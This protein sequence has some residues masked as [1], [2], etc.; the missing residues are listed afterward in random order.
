MLRAY[1]LPAGP[2]SFPAGT[3]P[4]PRPG[5]DRGG[6]P[7]PLRHRPLHAVAAAAVDAALDRR[8]CGLRLSGGDGQL[9]SGLN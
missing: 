8:R 6:A 5:L 1:H 2:D 4:L 3:R 9:G 7:L